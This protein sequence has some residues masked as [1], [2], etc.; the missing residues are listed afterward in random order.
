MN[1]LKAHLE[2]TLELNIHKI[3]EHMRSGIKMYLLEGI[4]P[5][6]FLFSVLSNDLKGAF[7]RA[8]SVNKLHLKD[9]VEFMVWHLPADAQGSPENVISWMEWASNNFQPKKEQ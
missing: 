3:P 4:E 7:S 9:W 6:G 2:K 8:D 1:D 5:G